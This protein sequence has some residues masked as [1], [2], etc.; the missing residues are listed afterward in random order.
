M[1]RRIDSIVSF[2]CR[3]AHNGDPA[4]IAEHGSIV[5]AS[6]YGIDSVVRGGSKEA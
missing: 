6:F 4:L 1:K 5:M 3:W 2:Y